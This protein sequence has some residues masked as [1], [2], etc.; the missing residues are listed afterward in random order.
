MPNG[1][2]RWFWTTAHVNYEGQKLVRMIGI[3]ADITA[4]K[5]IELQLQESEARMRLAQKAAKIATWDLHLPEEKLVW[6]EGVFDLLGVPSWQQPPPSLD[7][8]MGYLHEEDRLKLQKLMPELAAR[9]GGFS[10]EYRVVRADGE[11]R[12]ILA[13]GDV[14]K[15]S[16]GEAVRMIGVNVDITERKKAEELL[17]SQAQTLEELVRARTERL[18]EVVMELES[19][20]YTIAHDLRGPLRAMNGFAIAL[21]E[22]YAAQLD[23]T[24]QDYVRRITGAAERMDQLICDVLNYS[25]ITRQEYEAEPVELEPL[26]EGILET[27]PTLRGEQG[28]ITLDRP[29]PRVMGSAPLLL[30]IFSNLIGNAVKF[31]PAGRRPEVRVWAEAR[32]KGWVRLWVEDNGIGI[33][34]ENFSRIFGLFQ[35]LEKRFDGTGIGLAIVSRAVDRMGGKCGLES[36]EGKGSRFWAELKAA[37]DQE[38]AMSEKMESTLQRHARG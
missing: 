8:W 14:E 23:G 20:S 25:K 15:S 22:D 1:A 32:E 31:V 26:L 27:Y 2:V 11:V 17:Q 9:G 18:Q 34:P 28:T 16:F 21:R 19:F 24:A 12:W 35:R 37:P 38:T 6:S 30:Q 3:T 29:F 7:Q 4:R 33:A 10:T 36:E 5:E 13:L